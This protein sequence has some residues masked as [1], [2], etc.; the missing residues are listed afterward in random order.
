MPPQDRVGSGATDTSWLEDGAI[1]VEF[2]VAGPGS[3][4][5]AES[6]PGGADMWAPAPGSSENVPTSGGTSTADAVSSWI[7][8]AGSSTPPRE[9]S[10]RKMPDTISSNVPDTRENASPV[11][12][13]DAE[14]SGGEPG[15]AGIAG[16]E[17]LAS[18]ASD[19]DAKG[20]DP[21][22]TKMTSAKPTTFLRHGLFKQEASGSVL[23]L[24]CACSVMSLPNGIRR[25]RLCFPGTH[26]P[27]GPAGTMMPHL[28]HSFRSSFPGA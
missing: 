28:S 2:S 15:T 22:T 13:P 12:G 27:P 21:I 6:G 19:A 25:M 23:T 14:R 16:D 7:A 24:R 5:P 9:N 17:E 26:L 3:V 1:S 8:A 4:H 10:S 11:M 20:T 18:P